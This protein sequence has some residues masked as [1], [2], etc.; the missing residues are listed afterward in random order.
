[1]RTLRASVTAD[2]R[3][4][5]GLRLRIKVDTGELLGIELSPAAAQALRAGIARPQAAPR[6]TVATQAADAQAGD[7]GSAADAPL[8]EGD[9][10]PPARR[11]RATA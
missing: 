11:G 8:T 5:G 2:L 10:P 7:Q 9:P 1:M 4:G 6:P 3:D